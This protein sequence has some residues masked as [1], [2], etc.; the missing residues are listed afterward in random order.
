MNSDDDFI[1]EVEGYT[2]VGEMERDTQPQTTEGDLPQA[3]HPARTRSST[4][5]SA[6]TSGAG[7]STSGAGAWTII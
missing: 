6:S 3:M 1:R 5:T 2:D 7:A 4:V